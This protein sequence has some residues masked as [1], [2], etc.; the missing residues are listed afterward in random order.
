MCR[1]EEKV[2]VGLRVFSYS[3]ALVPAMHCRGFESHA[4]GDEAVDMGCFPLKMDLVNKINFCLPFLG[5]VDILM[6]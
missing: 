4:P 2:F 6:P 1:G 3:M 5:Q